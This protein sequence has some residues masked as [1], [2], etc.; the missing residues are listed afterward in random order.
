MPLSGIKKSEK[1]LS[2]QPEIITETSR[3]MAIPTQSK[4]LMCTRG[5]AVTAVH[6]A[7]MVGIVEAEDLDLVAARSEVLHFSVDELR[8]KLLAKLK[9][10]IID[11][12][13]ALSSE[14]IPGRFDFIAAVGR[15]YGDDVLRGT[16][17]PWITAV[18]R[19]GNSS[20]LSPMDLNEKFLHVTEVLI[21]YGSSPWHATPAAKE[22]FPTATNDALVLPIPRAGQDSPVSFGDDRA[23]VR[24][25]ELSEHFGRGTVPLTLN[26]V[27]QIIADAWGVKLSVLEAGRWCRK[28]KTTS[29]LNAHF[30]KHALK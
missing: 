27:L 21:S 19:Q 25:G 13:N 10:Q 11:S 23:G 29:N 18:D 12:L 15:V 3:V 1:W 16:S 22:L 5:I 8:A 17:L 24:V 30:A 14:F 28:S 9:P 7:G 6:M 4:V 2:R 20:L 26:V